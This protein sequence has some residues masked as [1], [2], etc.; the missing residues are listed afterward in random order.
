MQ[1]ANEPGGEQPPGTP[2]EG[3]P[4]E[5]FLLS[6]LPHIPVLSVFPAWGCPQYASGAA[7]CVLSVLSITRAFLSPLP[8]PILSLSMC[9]SG[10]TQ[11]LFTALSAA[12]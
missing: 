10:H 11:A 9:V 7:H 5:P 2:E 6:P 8:P 1:G 4:S 3:E 12:W